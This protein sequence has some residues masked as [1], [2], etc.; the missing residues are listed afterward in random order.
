MSIPKRFW[1]RI[2]YRVY[3]S[4]IIGKYVKLVRRGE[5]GKG[6]WIGLC[7]FHDEKTPSF[8]VTDMKSFFHCFGC[9]QNGNVFDFLQKHLDMSFEEAVLLVADEYAIKVPQGSTKT[10][11]KKL[12]DRKRRQKVL[13]RKRRKKEESEPLM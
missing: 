7:P 6:E 8:S 11:K 4:D 5:K 2:E 1:R 10:T 13:A 12:R 9:G 3:P